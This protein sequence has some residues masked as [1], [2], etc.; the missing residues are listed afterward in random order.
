MARSL[1]MP[2]SKRG[3]KPC[4][5]ALTDSLGACIT[6]SGVQLGFADHRKMACQRYGMRAALCTSSLQRQNLGPAYGWVQ[7]VPGA[8]TAKTVW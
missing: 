4:A 7:L 1:H 3:N 5:A 2:N 8:G 6:P